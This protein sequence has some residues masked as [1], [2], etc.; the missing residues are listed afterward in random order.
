MQNTYFLISVHKVYYV[1]C[2]ALAQ[3][4]GWIESV[5]WVSKVGVTAE[6]AYAHS[7][8]ITV[9]CMLTS[10]HKST[11]NTTDELHAIASSYNPHV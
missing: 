7:C 8:C 10:R 4:P 5:L 11:Q 6:S 9:Y 1:I 2:D 3:P